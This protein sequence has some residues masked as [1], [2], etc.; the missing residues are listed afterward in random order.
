MTAWVH[1]GP[2]VQD[3]ERKITIPSISATYSKSFGQTTMKWSTA[4]G[5]LFVRYVPSY[6][7]HSSLQYSNYISWSGTLKILWCKEIDISHPVATAIEPPSCHNS[8]T[9]VR[10]LLTRERSSLHI[11]HKHNRVLSDIAMVCDPANGERS[12]QNQ[13][14]RSYLESLWMMVISTQY[15]IHT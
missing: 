13:I 3:L 7:T 4:V 10:W 11:R 15:S 9:K 8:S 14:V 5:L 2:S 1:L 6:T 12:D